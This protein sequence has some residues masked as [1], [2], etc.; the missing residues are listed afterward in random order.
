MGH[1]GT[2]PALQFVTLISVTVRLGNGDSLTLKKP[3]RPKVIFF[4]FNSL[5]VTM[6]KDENMRN[7][8]L[9]FKLPKNLRRFLNNKFLVFI[10][11]NGQ[12]SKSY[13]WLSLLVTV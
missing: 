8:E 10:A 1:T 2:H 11:L 3:G 12:F 13:R 4:F 9:S 5:K 6:S 7:L